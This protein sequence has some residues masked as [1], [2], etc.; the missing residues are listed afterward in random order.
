MADQAASKTEEAPKRKYAKEEIVFIR[1]RVVNY[2]FDTKSYI[3]GTDEA[4]PNP[5]RGEYLLETVNKMGRA[6]EQS[7]PIWIIDAHL[8]SLEEAKRAVRR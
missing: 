2:D 1:C 5:D 7:R 8:V 3:V 6:D 4:I